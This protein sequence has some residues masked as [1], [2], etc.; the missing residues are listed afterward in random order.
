MGQQLRK[1]VKRKARARRKKRLKI[2]AK[3]AKKATAKSAALATSA[4]SDSRM[5]PLASFWRGGFL[6]G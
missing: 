5:N 3:L 1:I 6:R 4:P 2:T